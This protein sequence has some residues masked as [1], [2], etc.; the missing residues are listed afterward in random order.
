MEAQLRVEIISNDPVKPSCP[1]PPERKTI[2]L[3][4]LDESFPS[5]HVPWLLIFTNNESMK[6]T[7]NSPII[8]SLKISLSETLTH[9]FPL[10]GRFENEYNVSCNDQGIP[11]IVTCV[12]CQLKDYLNLPRKLDIGRKLLPP[13]DIA[14]FGQLPITTVDPLAFQV[15]I[16]VCVC[17][18]VAIRCYSNHK[19]IDATSLSNFLNYWSALASRRYEDLV[20]PNFETIVKVFPPVPKEKR[21]ETVSDDARVL[22]P[23]RL[24]HHHNVSIKVLVKSFKFN[25]DVINKLKAKVVSETV[26]NPSNFEAVVGFVWM[27]AMGA[28]FRNNNEDIAPPQPIP[29]VLSFIISL[30]SRTTPPLPNQTMGNII[31]SITSGRVGDGNGNVGNNLDGIKL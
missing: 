27:H 14:S 4:F 11:F 8:T 30:Q 13:E 6:T 2:T 26:P 9:F 20:E 5:I 12:E 29:T 22:A 1:T 24:L 19:L 28:I 18:G 16:F 25:N 17:G 21:V 7:L 15:N 10:A 3:S 23:A 31:A